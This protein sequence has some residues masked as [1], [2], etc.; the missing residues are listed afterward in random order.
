MKEKSNTKEYC[1]FLKF[2][3]SGQVP[4]VVCEA[5]FRVRMQNNKPY[6]VG[7]CSMQDDGFAN[8]F[9]ELVRPLPTSQAI[10]PEENAV[11]FGGTG[12]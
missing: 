2:A 11:R 6:V 9:C 4:P 10:L 5:N 12:V 8:R 7:G 1:P 3:K